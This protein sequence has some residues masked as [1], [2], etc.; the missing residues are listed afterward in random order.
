MAPAE[1]ITSTT[2]VSESGERRR[3]R[4]RRR[5]ALDIGRQEHDVVGADSEHDHDEQ[6]SEFRSTTKR[7]QWAKSAV[8]DW[9]TLMNRSDH[10]DG[11]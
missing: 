7:N 10:D 3:L 5:R 4:R 8:T 9:A 11:D 2:L 1:A 6:R